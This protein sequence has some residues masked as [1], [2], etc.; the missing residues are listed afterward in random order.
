MGA[1]TEDA[2]RRTDDSTGGAGPDAATAALHRRRGPRADSGGSADSGGPAESGEPAILLVTSDESL[3]DEI[4][5]TAAVVGARTDAREAWPEGWQRAV[6]PGGRWAAVLCSPESAACAGASTDG[7]LVVGRG[8]AAHWQAAA[9]RPAAVPVPLPAAE[10]WLGEHLAARATDRLPGRAVLVAGSHGGVGASTVAFLAAAEAAA[11]DDRVLLVDA[12]PAPGSGL[13]DLLAAEAGSEAVLDWTGIAATEGALAPGHLASALPEVEGIHVLTGA[14]TQALSPS[15]VDRVLAAGRRGFDLVVVD[16]GR[17]RALSVLGEGGSAA[18]ASRGDAAWDAGLLVSSASRRGMRG[19]AEVLAA[20]PQIP[21]A[22]VS[23]GAARPGWCREDLAA[24]G[25][26]VAADLPEQKWLR[27]ADDLA[28][29]YELLRTR[30][31][32]TFAAAL[33]ETVGAAD[34]AG[35]RTGPRAA[36]VGDE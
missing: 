24:L 34:P 20:R 1:H 13:R 16:A 11:R 33:L 15:L 3:R 26:P 29:A 35:V 28:E 25:S 12:D 21:W 4:T 19:A 2:A 23:S 17:G 8:D 9:E 6:G 32:E 5:L 22:V 36:A 10:S 18:E 30:R 31:G 7:L 27:R 14:P